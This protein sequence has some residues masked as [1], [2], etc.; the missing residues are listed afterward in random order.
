MTRERKER[1][2]EFDERRNAFRPSDKR[3][4]ISLFDM[5][6]HGRY[7]LM[8]GGS[9]RAKPGNKKAGPLLPRYMRTPVQGSGSLL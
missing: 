9:S 6:H 5:K 7:D 2:A 3:M 8:W 1:I 4:P